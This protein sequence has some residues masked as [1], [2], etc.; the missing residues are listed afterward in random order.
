MNTE[1][2]DAFFAKADDVLTDWAESPDSMNTEPD[3]LMTTLA[4][5]FDGLAGVFDA[6]NRR[7][8]LFIAGEVTYP[9]LTPS[10]Y[11]VMDTYA[12]Q[13]YFEPFGGPRQALRW[14]NTPPR[15]APA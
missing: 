5:D 9:G 10:E 3:N 15:D 7:V 2:L 13:Q 8:E 12:V 6:I 1:S 11:V 14:L 4:S